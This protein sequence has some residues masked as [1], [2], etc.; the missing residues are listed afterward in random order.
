MVNKGENCKNLQGPYREF[1]KITCCDLT[2]FKKL[3][4]QCDL[5]IFLM[6]LAQ[7]LEIT[8]LLSS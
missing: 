6:L 7:L 3:L 2:I 8:A 5:T 1:D 4:A